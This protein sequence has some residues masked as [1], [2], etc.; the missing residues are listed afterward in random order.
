MAFINIFNNKL[1]IILLYIEY[2]RVLIHILIIVSCFFTADIHLCDDGTSTNVWGG[3]LDGKPVTV[4]YNN[5]QD[6]SNCTG[7]R[8]NYGYDSSGQPTWSY[9]VGENCVEDRMGRPIYYQ[10]YD[11]GLFNTSDGYRYE[12]SGCSG[13]E[14]EGKHINVNMGSVNS[15]QIGIIEP[16]KS[17]IINKGYY[18]GGPP[19]VPCDFSNS[20]F[21]RRMYNKVKV[22]VKNHINKSNEES[23]RQDFY[24]TECLMKDIRHSR[25]I[26]NVYNTKRLSDRMNNTN[27][28]VKVR[29]FD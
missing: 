7:Y 3:E 15:T 14:L 22:A 27:Y 24:K 16:T 17:E 8:G 28:T 1:F 11:T 20:S 21:K 5:N 12:V 25:G 26:N 9:T 4:S 29:R 6:Y 23:L 19:V 2:Y 13:R 10:A 18:Q